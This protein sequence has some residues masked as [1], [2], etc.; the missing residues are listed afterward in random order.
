MTMATLFGKLKEHEM[1]LERLNQTEEAN[2]KKRSLAL[3][4]SSSKAKR[5]ESSDDEESSSE[6]SDDDDEHINMLVRKFGKFMKKNNFRKFRGKPRYKRPNDSEPSKEKVSCFECGKPGHFR[7]ECPEL[8]EKEDKPNK[9]RKK[10]AY[11]AWDNSSESSSE[12]ESDVRANLCLTATHHSDDEVNSL[13]NDECENMS[14]DELHDTCLELFENLQK[15]TRQLSDKKKDIKLKEKLNVDLSNMLDSMKVE[16]ES[17]KKENSALR[18]ELD[19]S[20]KSFEKLN[21][22]YDN[23]KITFSKYSKSTNNLNKLLE[24]QIPVNVKY[25]IGFRS[26]NVY[27]KPIRNN[28]FIK[29]KFVPKAKNTYACY[30]CN[31]IGHKVHNCFVKSKGM[32]RGT[33]V[34]VERGKIPRTNPQGPKINWVPKS[35][36]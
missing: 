11:I 16:N 31:M 22:E 26:K 6:S 35:T 15:V 4:A 7:S 3:K 29:N 19:N 1:E 20:T 33:Y 34:W 17:L 25:G 9:L 5:K 27:E 13:S 28:S 23:S 32:P 2:N 10:K 14:Y 30:H 18:A 24:S 21:T 8:K 12:S 36:H